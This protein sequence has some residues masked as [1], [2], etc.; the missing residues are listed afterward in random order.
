MSGYIIDWFI[1]RERKAALRIMI[2]S[3]VLIWP[4]FLAKHPGLGPSTETRVPKFSSGIIPCIH[5]ALLFWCSRF[6]ISALG[7]SPK[8][9]T[10]LTLEKK[11]RGLIT[12]GFLI[13]D[14]SGNLNIRLVWD[15]N[16]RKKNFVAFS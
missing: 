8:Y 9:P 11:I 10:R 15:L 7:T 2:K 1:D 12:I 5:Q 4:K 16:G 6:A 13:S 3:Y 14:W